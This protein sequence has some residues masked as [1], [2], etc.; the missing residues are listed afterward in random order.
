MSMSIVR[1]MQFQ[2]ITSIAFQHQQSKSKRH[3]I[4]IE[5]MQFAYWIY[6]QERMTRHF[7]SVTHRLQLHCGQRHTNN[8]PFHHTKLCVSSWT[9]VLLKTIG[10]YLSLATI[11]NHEMDR[12]VAISSLGWYMQLDSNVA[13]WYMRLDWHE[14]KQTIE[15]LWQESNSKWWHKSFGFC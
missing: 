1:I 11:F 14:Q 13:C 15:S 2:I 8:R 5:W 10:R 7:F 9:R 12:Y 6:P 4:I 3:H